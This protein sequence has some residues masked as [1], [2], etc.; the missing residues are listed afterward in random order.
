MKR[1]NE[2]EF[3]SRMI[4]PLFEKSNTFKCISGGAFGGKEAQV[5]MAA[6]AA[7]VG[8]HK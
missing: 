4:I 6:G 8:A 2:T 1:H 3:C 5:M 7:A